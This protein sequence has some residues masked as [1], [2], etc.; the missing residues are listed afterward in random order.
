METGIYVEMPKVKEEEHHADFTDEEIAKLWSAADKTD[1]QTAAMVKMILTMIY[2]G[3]RIGAWRKMT[4]ENDV[5]IGGVKTDAGNNRVVPIH[6]S[7]TG[8]VAGMYGEFLCGKSESQFR[9]DMRR[10]LM[11]I[12]IDTDEKY[13]TPHSCRHTFHR[14]LEKAGVSEADRKRL[15]GHSLKGDITNGTYGHRSVE[16]LKEQIEKIKIEKKKANS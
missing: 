15:M 5:F 12:E 7:I 9:R 4:V 2:S 10:V 3:F 13:H 16:E 6:S 14:L 11:E 8:F 1:E